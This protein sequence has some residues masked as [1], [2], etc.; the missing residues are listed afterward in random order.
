MAK[1]IVKKA[2]KLYVPKKTFK[3]KK[4]VKKLTATLKNGKKVIKG[5][6]IVFIINKKKESGFT[7]LYFLPLQRL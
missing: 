4:K 5:R 7:L 6:K 1:K 2:T 3:A